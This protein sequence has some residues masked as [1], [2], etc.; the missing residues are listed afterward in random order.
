MTSQEIKYTD[1]TLPGAAANLALDEALL[2]ACETGVGPQVLRFWESP[3]YFVVVGYGNQI[4][5][6]VD[7]DECQARGIPVLRRCS[8]GGTVLQGPGCLSYT[9]I[10]RI[11]DSGPLENIVQ[12]NR[13]IMDRN[14]EAL[15]QALG[16][17]VQVQGITDLSLDSLKFS[18]NAQRR[19]RRALVFHGTFLL[20]FDLSLIEQLLPMPSKEP[21]YREKR[22]HET[23]LTNLKVPAATVKDALR[24]AWGARTPLTEVPDICALVREKYGRAEWNWRF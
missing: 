22:S 6:E 10:L 15:S 18:G 1:I 7:V 13:Y 5:L 20:N 14:K 17:P 12:T 3:E 16:W 9:L 21:D 23:F 4:G 8:G 2:D 24:S 19:K 11:T